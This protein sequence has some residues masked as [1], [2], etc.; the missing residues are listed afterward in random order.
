MQLIIR[1]VDEV[2]DI[3]DDI[4]EQTEVGDEIAE[5]ISGQINLDY[6]EVVFLQ[7]FLRYNNFVNFTNRTV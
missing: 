4:S 6:D 5:A 3:M 2:H 1:T 7:Y